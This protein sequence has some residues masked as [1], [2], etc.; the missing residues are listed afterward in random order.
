MQLPPKAISVTADGT[1]DGWAPQASWR[2][3]AAPDGSTRLVISLPPE[4]LQERHLALIAALEGPLGVRYV[5][6]TDRAL[7][8]A[9]D[10]PVTFVRMGLPKETVL[11]A[12]RACAPLLWH[13]GRHQLWIRG[14]QGEQVVLDELGVIYC[15]PD[16]FSF[17]D[18]VDDLP[19]IEGAGMDSRDY[20]RVTFLAEADALERG[21]LSGL[22]L[23]RWDV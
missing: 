7:G 21:L 11:E 14:N 22:G 18:V 2:A 15:Y 23:V 9:H 12:L 19:S 16:D 5:Q 20:V 1:P 4:Q 10:K 6:L 17:R 3:Q 8:R 13:D